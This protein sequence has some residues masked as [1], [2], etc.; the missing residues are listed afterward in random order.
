MA[1]WKKY[2]RNKALTWTSYESGSTD[3][4]QAYRLYTLALAKAP[5]LGAMNRLKEIKSLSSQARWRLAATYVLVG[6]KSVCRRV[7]TNPIGCYTK[8][9]G[10]EFDI[11]VRCQG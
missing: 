6:Q 10:D 7:D 4:I 9:S 3:L 2:Q 8:I 11:R 1:N 5:E